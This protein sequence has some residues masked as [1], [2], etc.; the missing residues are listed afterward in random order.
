M[1]TADIRPTVDYLVRAS[2]SRRSAM[3]AARATREFNAA[4]IGA[5]AHLYRGEIYR[6]TAWRTRLDNTTNWAVAGLGLAMSISFSRADASALPI[7][8]MGVLTVVFLFFEARRYRYFNVF[9]ARARWMETS[10]MRQCFLER[11]A[12]AEPGG[13][14]FSEDYREP[15]FHITLSRAIEQ[16]EAHLRL[17][18]DNPSLGLS[19]QDHHSPHASDQFRRICTARRYWPD[20]RGSDPGCRGCLHWRL[21]HFGVRYLLFGSGN[22]IS[23]SPTILAKPA[24]VHGAS[25]ARKPFGPSTWLR[26]RSSRMRRKR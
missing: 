2:R 24:A 16:V 15:Q 17:C 25:K 22:R 21:D 13:R 1:P 4:E 9:R 20:T 7:L 8:L 14:S 11:A 5:L 18:P 10:F 26:M 3:R 19:R 23:S 12:S 6:S